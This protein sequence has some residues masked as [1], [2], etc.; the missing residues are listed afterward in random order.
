MSADIQDI[1]NRLLSSHY[2][3]RLFSDLEPFKREGRELLGNCPFCESDRFSISTTKPLWKCWSCGESGDYLDYLQNQERKDFSEAL[4][5]LGKEAGLEVNFDSDYQK[6]YQKK[7]KKLSLFEEAQ[8]LFINSLTPDSPQSNYL[9]HTRKYGEEIRLMQLGAYPYTHK[10]N[11]YLL[12]KGFSEE[13]IRD[14][15]LLNSK[16]K[17]RIS[18]PYPNQSGVISGFSFRTINDENKPKY[19]NTS[20]LNKDGERWFS[21]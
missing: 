6:S 11:N 4:I 12:Q 7:K 2:Y 8:T 9:I 15:G 17:G 1:Y 20:G 13:E 10:I 21:I 14:S 5:E 3:E 18:I 19:L 16:L